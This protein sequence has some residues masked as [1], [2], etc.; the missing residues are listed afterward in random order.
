MS[1]C[2]AIQ[3][4]LSAYLDGELTQQDSQRVGVHLRQCERCRGV[5]EDFAR[6][7][8]DIREM[9]FP[10]PPADAWSQMMSGMTFKATRGLGWLLWGGGAAVLAVY[11][12]YAFATDPAIKAIER[13]CV[14]AIIL[15]VAL[16]FMTV[17]AE[18]VVGLK[19]D[20]YRDVQK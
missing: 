17:L 19:T 18:R 14:L 2:E 7:R 4:K 12:I 8:A 13:V 1:V 10:E 15:G 3:A 11:A 9:P 16:V 6:M 5:V 20:K